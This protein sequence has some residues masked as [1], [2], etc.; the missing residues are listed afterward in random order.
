MTAQPT[1]AALADELAACCSQFRTDI[2]RVPAHLVDR[3]I[4]VLRKPAERGEEP[5]GH[6]VKNRWPNGQEVYIQT[7]SEI[8]KL[9]AVPLFLAPPSAPAAALRE[10]AALRQDVERI[11]GSLTVAVKANEEHRNRAF[12]AEALLEEARAWIAEA[13]EMITGYTHEAILT[14]IDAHIAEEKVR[15][16]GKSF[17]PLTKSLLSEGGPLTQEDAHVAARKRGGA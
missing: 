13:A 2:R 16:G 1:D 3:I 8:D 15:Y 14:K 5:I 17:G 4:E 9:Q 7:F 6:F 10:N 11:S 12:S